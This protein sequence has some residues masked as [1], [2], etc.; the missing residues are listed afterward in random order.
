MYEWQF[1][2]L[3]YA[4]NEWKDV[5]PWNA[6]TSVTLQPGES[7]TYGLQ[8]D[9]APSIRQI[10][11]TLQDLKRPVAVGIP[12]Y[13]LPQDQVG[14]LFLSFGSAVRSMS[15]SPESALIWAQNS[16]SLN[17]SWVGYD[18]TPKTW[19]RSRLTINYA[20]GTIQTVHYYVTK[21]ATQVI[22]DLGHFH[23]TE[24]WFDN[25]SD[26][27]NRSPSV[28]TYDREVNAPVRD[29]PRVWIPGLSNEA[30]AG[31]FLAAGVKQYVQPRAVEAAKMELFINTTLWG[32]V[33]NDGMYSCGPLH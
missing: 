20:D 22:S 26:P 14:K 1:H 17:A 5:I 21:A 13:I 30:G 11:D 3:A 24:M 12:G 16:D 32:S 8:F 2:T 23:T 19:G 10:E 18:I 27:F 33:Q 15:V 25:A 28:L 31:S 9:L 29:D 7:R 6:P 4:E